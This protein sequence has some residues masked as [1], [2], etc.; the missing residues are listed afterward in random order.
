MKKIV[1]LD[2]G[3]D[4]KHILKNTLVFQ[5]SCGLRMVMNNKMPNTWDKLR[6]SMKETARKKLL[7]LIL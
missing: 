3:Q 4:I 5:L 7:N 2:L 6:Y 1:I